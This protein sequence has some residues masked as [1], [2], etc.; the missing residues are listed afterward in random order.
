MASLVFA[1]PEEAIKNL[2]HAA[3]NDFPVCHESLHLFVYDRLLHKAHVVGI[4]FL[5][6]L[7]LCTWTL[8]LPVPS[9]LLVPS[10]MIGA[11]KH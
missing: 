1:T 7:L 5:T 8:G 3:R 6:S 10:L 4:F 9:G 2:F 11:V